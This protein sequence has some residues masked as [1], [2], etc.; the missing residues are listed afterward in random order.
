MDGAARLEEAV[1][2][3]VGELREA[4][5]KDARPHASRRA[6]ADRRVGARGLEVVD[7]VRAVARLVGGAEL[8]VLQAGDLVRV[9]VGVGVRV[10]VR[11]RGLGLEG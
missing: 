11:V 7:D 8:V 5:A 1:A 3:A 4:V 9:S 10:R 6:E 2:R